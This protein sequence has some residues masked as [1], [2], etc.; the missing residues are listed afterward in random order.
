MTDDELI[1]QLR[2]ELDDL[3]ADV[4]AAPAALTASFTPGAARPSTS[5]RRWLPVGVAAASLTLL[6]GGL[7]VIANRDTDDPASDAPPP[8]APATAP[9]TTPATAPTTPPPATSL[10][11]IAPTTAPPGAS[12]TELETIAMVLESSEQGPQLCFSALESLP[13]QCGAGVAL[14]SWTWDLIDVEQVQSGTTWVDSIYVAGTYDAAARAFAVTDARLPTDADRER[15]IVFP[16]PDFSVPCP[17]PEGGWP[18]RRQEW[19]GEQVAAIPGY[20]GAWVDESQQVMTVK[21]TGDLA[22]AEAAVGEVYSGSVCVLPASRDAAELQAIQEQLSQMSSIQFLS[23]AVQVDAAGESVVAEVIAPDP[24]R[25]AAFDAEF[26][27][28]VVR[29]LP[30]LRP[31]G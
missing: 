19:P 5:G 11:P 24:D 3:V 8:T 4:P 29:L 18:A 23:I 14:T 6:V 9:A 22:A 17:E 31:I 12:T 30:R 16:S 2:A 10:S 13:P 28:G 21:F 15:L 26:G 27:Q 7:I 25:Q 20:A 1:R